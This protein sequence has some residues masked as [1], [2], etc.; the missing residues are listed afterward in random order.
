[1]TSEEINKI[2]KNTLIENLG[3]E[4]FIN[5]EHKLYA[6]MPVD[7]R[8]I[9]PLGY[10]HGGASLAL[11]ESLGSAASFMMVDKSKIVFGVQVSANHVKT[12]KE[13][14]VK[15]IA[16]PVHFGK[17]THIWD[18]KIIDEEENLISTAR[19][20]NRIQEIDAK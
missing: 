20:T 6:S 3:I 16:E 15:A 7:K 14:V 10:L 9:Q 5:D 13:G 18:V 12:V 8:T 19:V 11:A 4:F 2:C 1:M 17:S